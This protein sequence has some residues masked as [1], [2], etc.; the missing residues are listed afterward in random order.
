MLTFFLAAKYVELVATDVDIQLL[1]QSLDS[2]EIHLWRMEKPKCFHQFWNI[3][4]YLERM[5]SVEDKGEDQ[6]Q[7]EGYPATQ[8]E[9]GDGNIFPL[10]FK[11]VSGTTVRIVK[12]ETIF[13]ILFTNWL[14]MFLHELETEDDKN[15][16]ALLYKLGVV[17]DL[18][19]S[20]VDLIVTE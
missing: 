1:L 6:R 9:V 4:I 5:D 10:M 8:K 19:T 20:Q 17:H 18:P 14:T 15:V 12:L 2:E 13:E 11:S 16:E 7:D 3:F